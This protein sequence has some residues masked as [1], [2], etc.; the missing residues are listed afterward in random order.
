M[1]TLFLFM[2][3]STVHNPYSLAFYWIDCKIKVS[4]STKHNSSLLSKSNLH[5]YVIHSRGVRST[6]FVPRSHVTTNGWSGQPQY[7]GGLGRVQFVGKGTD[8]GRGGTRRTRVRVCR[9]VFRGTTKNCWEIS[10]HVVSIHMQ[11]TRCR[12][13]DSFLPISKKFIC[14]AF[15][16]L[17]IFSVSNF[18]CT[19]GVDKFSSFSL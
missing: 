13:I 6:S 7:A 16:F 17:I 1:L 10:I 8:F 15:F 2:I 5:Y 9:K 18:W 11:I 12:L 19:L 4:H 3:V 14:S